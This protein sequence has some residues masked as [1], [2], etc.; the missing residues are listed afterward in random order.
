M[1]AH[2]NEL[3]ENRDAAQIGVWENEGGSPSRDNMDHHYGR[4]IEANRSWTVYHVFTGVPASVG[5]RAMT[6][7]DRSNATGAMMSLNLRNAGRRKQRIR[8]NAPKLD[9]LE[10]DAISS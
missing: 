5:G 4:R 10:I 1:N 9:M 2:S 7:L 3:D 8:L 6:G